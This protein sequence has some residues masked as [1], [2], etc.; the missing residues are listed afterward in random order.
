MGQ[1]MRYLSDGR[2]ELIG[3]EVPDPG[4]NE[5]QVTGGACGI[6]FVGFGYRPNWAIR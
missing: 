2:I 6:L 1:T 4:A 3:Q 5:V